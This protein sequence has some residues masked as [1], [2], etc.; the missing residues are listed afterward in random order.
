MRTEEMNIMNITNINEEE[1]EFLRLVHENDDNLF[2][3]WPKDSNK[4]RV[5]RY[6]TMTSAEKFLDE[7][8]HFNIF[9]ICPTIQVALYNKNMFINDVAKARKLS[10]RISKIQPNK[11]DYGNKN[12]IISFMS[13]TE[14]LRVGPHKDIDLTI[15][16]N[17]RKESVVKFVE[18]NR[19]HWAGLKNSSKRI[20]GITEPE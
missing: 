8:F 6:V 4:S 13:Y 19:N 2:Q 3:M 14:A 17:Y 11:I 20:I 9:F 5:L 15:L 10:D 12:N 1:K 7:N 16:D 18:R